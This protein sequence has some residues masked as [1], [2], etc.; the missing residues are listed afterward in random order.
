M[1]FTF[2]LKKMPFLMTYMYRWDGW[3]ASLT[4]W[5][6]VWTNSRRRWR[7]GKLS[8][9]QSIGSQRLGCD[10]TVIALPICITLSFLKTGFHHPPHSLLSVAAM[11]MNFNYICGSKDSSVSKVHTHGSRLQILFWRTQSKGLELVFFFF[12]LIKICWTNFKPWMSYVIR[13]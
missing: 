3:M 2:T 1:C 5:A 6:W 4:Q 13:T 12:R 7:T 9:L 8:V 10:W 11:T